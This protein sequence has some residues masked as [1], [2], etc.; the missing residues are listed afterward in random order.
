MFLKDKTNPDPT[1]PNITGFDEVEILMLF[2]VF[3]ELTFPYPYIYA[4]PN[5]Y[6]ILKAV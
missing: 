4:V 6:L 1:V 2:P 3:I 5:L